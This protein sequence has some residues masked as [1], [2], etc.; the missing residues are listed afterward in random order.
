MRRAS[1]HEDD[2]RPHHDL[3]Q[4]RAYHRNGLETDMIRVIWVEADLHKGM[5]FEAVKEG[6]ID[7]VKRKHAE[8]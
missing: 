6:I 5:F 2:E 7:E 1:A 3:A 4:E 8:E